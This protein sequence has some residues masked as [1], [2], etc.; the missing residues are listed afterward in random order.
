MEPTGHRDRGSHAGGNRRLS[1]RSARAAASRHRARR[2]GV[3]G[4][5][6]AIAHGQQ[7]QVWSGVG[8]DEPDDESAKADSAQPADAYDGLY[9]GMAT[10]RADGRPATFRVKVTNGIG[11][12]TQSRLDC[13]TAPI[14]LE[15]SPLGDVS[16]IAQIFGATCFKTDLAIRGRAIRGRSG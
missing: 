16:G 6:V 7:D 11:S 13:G 9:A 1:R 2:A 8:Q 15:T 3:Q 12:A 10:M 5:A 14:S 4:R